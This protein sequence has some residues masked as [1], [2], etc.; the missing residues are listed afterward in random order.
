MT[1]ADLEQNYDVSPNPEYV[2]G[3]KTAHQLKSEFLLAWDTCARDGVVTFAEFMD[4]YMDVSPT[5][6]SD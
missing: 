3:N 1:I 2:F 6:K 4:Y 5:I